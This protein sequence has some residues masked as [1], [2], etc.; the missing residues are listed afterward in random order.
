MWWHGG[1][2]RKAHAVALLF[3]LA[4]PVCSGSDAAAATHGKG[5]FANSFTKAA[6]EILSKGNSSLVAAAA[7][8]AGAQLVRRAWEGS[9][10]RTRV[11]N[12]LQRG[13][14]KEPNAPFNAV[15]QDRTGMLG[16]EG[17]QIGTKDN[18]LLKLMPDEWEQMRSTFSLPREWTAVTDE[19]SA[20][21]KENVDGVK[22]SV[23]E[24][25]ADAKRS[26][27][28]IKRSLSSH[29]FFAE[30]TASPGRSAS[31]EGGPMAMP[32]DAIVGEGGIIDKLT[33]Q[34]A[35]ASSKV[36]E[37][38]LSRLEHIKGHVA[39]ISNQGESTGALKISRLQ[40][41][42]VQTQNNALI[43]RLFSVM[44]GDEW[45]HV[46]CLGGVNVYRKRITDIQG[47]EKFYCIKAVRTINAKP[48]DVYDLLK[49][50][51]RISEYN[52]ECAQSEELPPLSEDTR[53]T[54]ACSKKYGPFK[55]RDFIT[56]VH[57]RRMSDGTMVVMSQS[58]DIDWQNQQ[59]KDYVRTEVL[60]AGNVIRPDPNDPSK[61]EFT[62]IAHVNPGGAADTP[63]GSRLVNHICTHGPVNFI[64][65]LEN[66]AGPRHGADKY[67][68][69]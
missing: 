9:Q 40:E 47:G 10:L 32:W 65:K 18:V 8:A 49:D 2:I 4:A 63:L 25:L 57:H 3:I 21:V 61:T 31:A 62:T 35:G 34:G 45:E 33:S 52:D 15:M 37:K 19:W 38:F 7:T 59:G 24:G 42:E 46:L 67:V 27:D 50:P 5:G 69:L 53:L 54:W 41:Q 20:K 16:A 17:E 48:I 22:A 28:S 1:V 55:A 56:R 13:R 11:D 43:G 30:R 6:Q 60:L 51:N 26:M 58:E 68:P 44:G 29:D 12:V 36:R 39:K 14:G 23:S 64:L 66:A